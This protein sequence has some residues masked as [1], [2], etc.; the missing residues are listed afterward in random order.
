[1]ATFNPRRFAQPDRLKEIASQRLSLFLQPFQTYLEGRGLNYSA[2]GNGIDYSLL[3]SILMNPN[4]KTPDDLVDALYFVHEMAT[5]EGMNQLLEAAREKGLVLEYDPNSSP[6]DIVIQVWN[7]DRDLLETQHAMALL[8]HPRSF[9]YFSGMTKSH[10]FVMPTEQTLRTL[11]EAMNDWFAD[12]RR[13]RGCKVFVFDQGRKVSI[14][15]RHGLPTKREGSIKEGGESSSIHYRPEKHDVLIYDRKF[16]ELAINAETKGE[17]EMYIAKIGW[18]LFGDEAFFPGEEKYTLSPLTVDGKAALACGDVEGLEWI[19]LRKIA[20]HKG[21][22]YGAV[23]AMKAT[24]LFAH[25]EEQCIVIHPSTRLMMATF[26]VKFTNAKRTRS[27]TIYPANKAQYTR[28]EDNA[29][30]EEWMGKRGFLVGVAE[31]ESNEE[32]ESTVDR[33]GNSAWPVVGAG[34]M[35]ATAWG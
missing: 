22:Q 3:A 6:A 34:G 9:I 2:N 21:G 25:L 18:H 30:L 27:V 20:I 23:D 11:E 4:D 16:V 15:V 10:K 35:A 26:E 7:Q 33:F 5:P 8:S 12:H 17:R 13:G 32:V 24:D 1:M 29:L 19:R 28:D 14:L 31:G